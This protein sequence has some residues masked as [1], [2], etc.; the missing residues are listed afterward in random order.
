[1]QLNVIDF[2]QEYLFEVE[3]YKQ[4]E[5]IKGAQEN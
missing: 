1:M 4:E 3:T 2:R 5:S